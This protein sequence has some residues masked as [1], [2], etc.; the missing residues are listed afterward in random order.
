MEMRKLLLLLRLIGILAM[1]E[2]AWAMMASGQEAWAPSALAVPVKRSNPNRS[3]PKST[4][5]GVTTFKNKA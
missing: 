4:A 1:T 2:S 3:M 5:T